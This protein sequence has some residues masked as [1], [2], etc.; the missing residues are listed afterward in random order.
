MKFIDRLDQ[1]IKVGDYIARPTSYGG[2]RVNELSKVVKFN[3][4]TIKV[5]AITKEHPDGKIYNNI[6]YGITNVANY[7][8]CIVVTEL[9]HKWLID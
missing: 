9:M 4:K 5:H 6:A 1:E 2:T 8:Q 3:P 7:N